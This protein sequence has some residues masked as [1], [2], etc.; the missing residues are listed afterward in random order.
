[1]GLVTGAAVGDARPG[2]CWWQWDA[3]LTIALLLELT[4]IGDSG[5]E[6]RRPRVGQAGGGG[7]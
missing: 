1:M 4:F 7:W 6:V 2:A 5:Q 3:K